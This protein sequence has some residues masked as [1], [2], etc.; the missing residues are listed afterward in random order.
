MMTPVG[1]SMTIFT[2][3]V[4]VYL[5]WVARVAACALATVV[6]H[7]GRRGCLYGFGRFC[8]NKDATSLSMKITSLAS[9][10][11]KKK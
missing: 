8:V 11:L 5:P 9:F 4:F 10:F 3:V 6:L 1:N 2:S 7:D